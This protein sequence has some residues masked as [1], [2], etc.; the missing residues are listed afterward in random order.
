MFVLGAVAGPATAVLVVIYLAIVIASIVGTVKIISKAGYS[1]WFVLLG[2]IP[3]VNLVM[4]FVFAF[5]EW[6]IQKELRHYRQGGVG[7]GY[8][9]P[10][11]PWP[12]QSPPGY[13]YGGSQFPQGGWPPSAPGEP[14]RT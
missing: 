4:F 2:L 6:P 14:P 5:S 1:G 13:G 7:P 8:G 10:A 9:Y 3:L 12:G 11:P